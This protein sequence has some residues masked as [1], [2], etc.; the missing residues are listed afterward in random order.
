[1]KDNPKLYGIIFHPRHSNFQHWALYLQSSDNDIIFEVEGEHPNFKPNVMRTKPENIAD[2]SHKIFIA[3]INNSDV[4]KLEHVVCETPVDNETAEWDGQE[5]V[6]DILERLEVE[7]IV[8][9]D[10]EEYHEA[11]EELKAKRGAV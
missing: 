3:E 4:Q 2:F 11:K 8:D 7:C 1:M 5:Y 9:K 6:F 10:D